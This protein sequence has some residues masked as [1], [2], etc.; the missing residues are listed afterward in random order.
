M[1]GIVAQIREHVR[2]TCWRMKVGMMEKGDAEPEEYLIQ[3]RRWRV[4]R[5]MMLRQVRCD[6]LQVKGRVVTYIMRK[7]KA[8]ITRSLVSTLIWILQT[9]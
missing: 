5:M 2:R 6:C 7:P 8:A 1:F 4:E 9:R 3:E